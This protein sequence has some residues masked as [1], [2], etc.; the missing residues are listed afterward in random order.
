MSFLGS[1]FGRKSV[2]ETDPVCGMTVN[3]QETEWASAHS[4]VT[5]FFCSKGCKESFEADP[6]KFATAQSGTTIQGHHS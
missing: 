6:A 4:G 5:Y 3:P 2:K 1:L